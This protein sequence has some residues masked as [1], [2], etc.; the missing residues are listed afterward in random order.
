MKAPI[1]IFGTLVLLLA[2][3]KKEDKNQNPPTPTE[4]KD[5]QVSPT[6]DWNTSRTFTLKFVGFT[7]VVPNASG[8]LI[9]T[10]LPENSELLRA[11]HVMKDN[12]DF[13]LNIPGHVKQI[14]VRYGMVEKDIQ[15]KGRNAEFSPIPE[16]KDEE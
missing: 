11:N 8:T 7:S 15:I 2:S 4:F 10:T 6:F 5:L 14:R 9:V 1:L 12:R 13:Q 3:C 16:F